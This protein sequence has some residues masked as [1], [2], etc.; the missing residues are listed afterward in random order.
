MYSMIF[1]EFSNNNDTKG[2]NSI[3]AVLYDTRR[4]IPVI[5]FSISK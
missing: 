3:S 5:F 4:R 1:L 2:E